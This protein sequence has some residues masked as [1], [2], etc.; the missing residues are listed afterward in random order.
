M[1]PYSWITNKSNTLALN[2]RASLAVSWDRDP[3]GGDGPEA[4]GRDGSGRLH[5]E[6]SPSLA[7]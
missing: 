3:Q 2:N 5:L 6:R 4:Q 1:V 7:E